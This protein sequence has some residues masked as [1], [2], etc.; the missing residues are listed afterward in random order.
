MNELANADMNIINELQWEGQLRLRDRMSR[1]IH[2][3]PTTKT[4]PDMIVSRKDDQ[5]CFPFLRALLGT[6]D[7]G[8][9]TRECS[10]IHDEV[11]QWKKS[12][13]KEVL[14]AVHGTADMIAALEVSTQFRN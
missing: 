7:T 12:E 5:L 14:K 2:T 3:P 8:C 6:N 10:R 1:A 4:K 13:V 11:L 9:N